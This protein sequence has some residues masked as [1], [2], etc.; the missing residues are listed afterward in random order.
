MWRRGRTAAPMAGWASPIRI[1]ADKPSPAPLLNSF[2]AAD[3]PRRYREEMSAWKADVPPCRLTGGR[4][5]LR[6]RGSSA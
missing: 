6:A 1:L 5:I 3:E 4:S 2:C